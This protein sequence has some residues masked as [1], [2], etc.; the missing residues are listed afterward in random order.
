MALLSIQNASLVL[1][2]K[3]ILD[4]T[5]VFIEQGDRLC[6]VGRNGVGKSTLLSVLAGRMAL[7]SGERHAEPGLR[8]GYVQQ[9]V[10]DHWQGSVFSVTAD[11]LG[12]EGHL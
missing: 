11:A 1:G 8:I 7:D 10:P 4:D 5:E 3:Q 2:S 12:R 6:I 9:A